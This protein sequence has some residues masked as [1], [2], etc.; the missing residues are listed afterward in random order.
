MLPHLIASL[1]PSPASSFPSSR[2]P[3]VRHRRL[4]PLAY[5]WNCSPVSC[6]RT[7]SEKD[8]GRRPAGSTDGDA[9]TGK[10]ASTTRTSGK[11]LL[12]PFDW[13]LEL[14]MKI[15]RTD[16]GIC[17]NEKATFLTMFFWLQ[18]TSLVLEPPKQ[19]AATGDS[20]NNHRRRACCDDGG[21]NFFAATTI[22]G[23]WNQQCGCCYQR[24]RLFPSTGMSEGWCF[25]NHDACLCLLQPTTTKATTSEIFC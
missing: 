12:Q 22:M 17:W 23:C 10:R 13:E 3:T 21:D 16:I 14:T 9:G 2:I 1:S 7:W 25:C 11:G 18:L 24:P 20:D 6:H 4:L 15:A 8:E 5:V 19:S